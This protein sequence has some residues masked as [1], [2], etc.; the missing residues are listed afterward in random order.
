MSFGVLQRYLN[1]I[2][3]RTHLYCFLADTKKIILCEALTAVA[4]KVAKSSPLPF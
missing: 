2:L 3:H 1:V 4:Q